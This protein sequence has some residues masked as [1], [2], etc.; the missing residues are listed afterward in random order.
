MD[1]HV[2]FL[3]LRGDEARSYSGLFGFCSHGC[4]ELIA[5]LEKFRQKTW[6]KTIVLLC[7]TWVQIRHMLSL[8]N[9][10]LLLRLW[11]DPVICLHG[12]VLIR[13]VC[14]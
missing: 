14:V 3:T 10:D 13:L 2:T 9:H 7:Q 12:L 8:N 6:S 5:S 1:T 4:V 11:N